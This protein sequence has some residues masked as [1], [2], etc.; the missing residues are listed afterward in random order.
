V[1]AYAQ[2]EFAPEVREQLLRIYTGSRRDLAALVLGTPPDEVSEQDA[3]SVGSLALAL[4]NGVML[5]WMLDPGTTP[6]AAELARAVG[7][8][9]AGRVGAA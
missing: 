5:Q 9:G 3:A 8:L 7:A 2:A 4:I 1:Q 6:S